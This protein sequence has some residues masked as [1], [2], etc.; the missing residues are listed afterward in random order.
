MKITNLSGNNKIIEG[1]NVSY[2]NAEINF[3]EGNNNII[4]LDD[5][6]NLG[7]SQLRFRGDSSMIFLRFNKYI[8]KLNLDI[9][10]N[11]ALYMGV[12]NYMNSTLSMAL[13]EQ[14]HIFIG[15]NCL[16]ST[17]IWIRTTDHHTIYSA[18]TRE[19]KNYSKSVFIGDHVWIGQNAMILKGT[20]IAS[21]S[22]LGAGSVIT[23]KRVSSNSAWAG[24]PAQKVST[25]IFWNDISVNNWTENETRQFSRMDTDIFIYNYESEINVSFDEIDKQLTLCRTAD[26]K[27]SYLIDIATTTDKNRFAF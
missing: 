3:N 16:F 18:K 11:S 4:F 26:A 14:K 12:N 21:G 24:N 7:N 1:E 27:M 15:D 9:F 19:R 23:N 13:A 25:D 5:G 8:Y 20:K 6:V 22:I 17:G 2:E 10:N